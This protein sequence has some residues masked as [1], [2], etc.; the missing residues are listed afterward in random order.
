MEEFV[1]YAAAAGPAM[2]SD[3]RPATP[4]EGLIERLRSMAK[5]LDS[6]MSI[7]H[8]RLDKLTGE[9]PPPSPEAT[10]GPIAIFPFSG[11]LGEL[12]SAIDRLESLIEMSNQVA[13]RIARLA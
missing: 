4:I 2:A 6:T 5:L 10:R 13:G 7:S 12:A 8:E 11:D 3:Q 9:R 1:R